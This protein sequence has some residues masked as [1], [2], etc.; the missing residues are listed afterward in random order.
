MRSFSKLRRI[1]V[2]I[3]TAT[4]TRNGVLD[5]EYLDHAARQ[6]AE[7]LK[8][9][10]EVLLV[11]SGAIGLG[12]MEM[13]FQT[14]PQSIPL[15]QALAAIGQPQLMQAWRA[16]FGAEGVKVAQVLVTYDVF[17]N[18]ASYLS[19]RNTVESLLSLGTI[20]V[21][22]ENDAI[23]I[24]EIARAFGDNDRLSAL[25]ASKVDADLLILLS[26][27][28]ALYEADPRTNPQARKIPEVRE[29][30]AELLSLAGKAGTAFS[31]GGMRTKL[32]AAQIAQK[33]GCSM[34]LAHGREANIITRLIQGEEIGTLFLPS[35]RLPSRKR[36][37]A[38]ALPQ[39]WI[40]VDEGAM[41]A[42]RAHKSLLPSGVRAVEGEFG[43]GSV[44]S[45][46][47]QIK[48]LSKYSGEELRKVMGKSLA[49]VEKI[50]GHR[51]VIARPEDMAFL[52]D[53][54]PLQKG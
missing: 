7:V 51:D 16:A 5:Q 9:G 21:F 32:H 11:T 13:G 29:I 43:S 24:A 53:I 1:V 34:I 44:V 26:D 47:G 27:V 19:L 14:R 22:N 10:I 17:S 42:L 15:R 18:R 36:W 33:A 31:T 30:G 35:E 3:G 45:V 49:E 25:V 39:G 23:S 20:P 37:L 48:L 6:M 12:A 50:L 4:L 8:Q 28:D 2:K 52:E 41:Q 40:T 54:D 38:L 46:N